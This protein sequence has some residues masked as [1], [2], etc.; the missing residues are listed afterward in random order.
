MADELAIMNDGKIVEEGNA[1]AIYRNPRED[2]TRRLI[3]AI[4][5]D[6]IE[7]IRARV[8]SAGGR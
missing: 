6:R 7:T 8:E 5:D 4:P 3:E 2:Y 1:E